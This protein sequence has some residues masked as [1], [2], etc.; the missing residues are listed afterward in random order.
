MVIH[1]DDSALA[2]VKGLI[3]N[4]SRIKH[5]YRYGIRFEYENCEE[6]ASSNTTIINIGEEILMVER[7][8]AQFIH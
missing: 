6:E 3:C 5:G 7:Q 1:T 8:T 2:E 4:R